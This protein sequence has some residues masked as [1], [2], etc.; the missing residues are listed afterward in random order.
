MPTSAFLKDA[1]WRAFRTFAQSA[2]AVLG[3]NQLD[4]FHANLTGVLSVA[5]GSALLSL[6]MSVDRGT[7]VAASAPA[8]VVSFA[9]LPAA[10]CG[11]N[12]KG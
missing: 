3:T 9:E 10:A 1:L 12:L 6:L 11:V 2:L 7:A 4:L 5:S 8:P